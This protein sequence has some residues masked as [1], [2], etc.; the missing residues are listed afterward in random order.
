MVAL[1]VVMVPAAALGTPDAQQGGNFM[2]SVAGTAVGSIAHQIAS[3]DAFISGDCSH[4]MMHLFLG[5]GLLGVAELIALPIKN[6]LLLLASHILT[7]HNTR[8]VLKLS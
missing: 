5:I 6:Y 1:L 2:V 8:V 4:L 7:A 3:D